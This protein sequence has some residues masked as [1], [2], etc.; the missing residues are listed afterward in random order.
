MPRRS[1]S[2]NSYSAAM[3]RASSFASS[4]GSGSVV[5]AGVS[6]VVAEALVVAEVVG[7]PGVVSLSNWRRR[8]SL[9][10][11]RLKRLES[12]AAVMARQAIFPAF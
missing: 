6:E 12:M 8:N 1:S 10:P 2:V 7:I 9:Q 11:V 5:S 4:L 3:V